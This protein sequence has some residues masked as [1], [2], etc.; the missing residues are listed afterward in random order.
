[1]AAVL[2]TTRSIPV[3][4]TEVSDPVAQGFVASLARP[5]G[6]ITGFSAF[7]FTVGGKWLDLLKKMAPSLT[8]A[9]VMFNPDT[10][11]QSSLFL[12][13]IEAAGPTLGVEVMA[14]PVRTRT[15]IENA[16][17]TLSHQPNSGLMLPTDTFTVVHNEMIVALVGRHKLT[18]ISA[19][20]LFVRSAGLMTYT[21]DF[22]PQFRQAAFYVDRFFKGTHLGDL[23]VQLPTKYSL[24]VNL[25]TAA[26]YGI[27]VPLPILMSV[28]EVVE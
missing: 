9:A 28:D 12:R 1:L 16:L 24:L 8:R 21:V 15:D 14:A 4:F 17:D 25:K 20:P 11:P 6:N 7:E 2:R 23:P 10:S 3:I 13:S 27:E 5:G 22:E 18:A 26:A 19:S